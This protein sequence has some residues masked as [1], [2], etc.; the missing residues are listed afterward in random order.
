MDNKNIQPIECS[1]RLMEILEWIQG[2]VLAD[3]GCDHGYVACNAIIMGKSKKS[4][5]C[6]IAQGPL[7][8]AKMTIQA[9]HL[10]EEVIPVLMNGM[11]NLPEDVNVVTIAG[12]GA[13]T[14]LDILENA[15]LKTGL[16]LLLSPHKDVEKLRE[17]LKDFSIE[18]EREKIVFDEGHYYPILDCVVKDKV[19]SLSLQETFL[20]KNVV[21]NVVYAQYLSYEKKK[22]TRILS[23]MP[24]GK[25]KELRCKL[26][27]IEKTH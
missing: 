18:I 13:S 3:I 23:N 17:K 11:E 22:L 4:Y 19:A 27:M 1:K 6:D 14:I 15:P 26:E 21:S 16:R 12:M 25:G 2:D 10:E 5:A 24:E 7:E 20:G 9:C 8:R